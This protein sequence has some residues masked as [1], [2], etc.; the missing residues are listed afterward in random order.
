[1]EMEMERSSSMSLR[2]IQQAKE[3]LEMLE[4]QHP[5]RFHSLK[6]DLKSFIFL[7]SQNLFLNSNCNSNTSSSSP[8]SSQCPHHKMP[9]ATSS[10]ATTQAS[11][12]SSRKR[13]RGIFDDEESNQKF[14]R[15]DGDRVDVVLKRAEVCLQ[16]IQDLKTN[17]FCS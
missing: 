10:F 6:L 7:H 9:S 15:V 13:K 5:N 1:M 16:K 8:S 17:F 3:E 14:Q 12:N 11:S 4:A 2:V